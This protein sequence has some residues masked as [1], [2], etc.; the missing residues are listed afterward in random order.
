MQGHVRNIS[1]HPT[2]VRGSRNEKY[3]AWKQVDVPAILILNGAM[4][5]KNGAGMRGVA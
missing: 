5:R 4:A 3:S 1:D 2:V